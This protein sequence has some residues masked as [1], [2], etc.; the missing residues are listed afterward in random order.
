[1]KLGKLHYKKM[2]LEELVT[3]AQ[4]EDFKALEEIVRREQ[5]NIFATFF[6]KNA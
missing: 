4:Q 3:L 5:K 2:T 6:L 1:M